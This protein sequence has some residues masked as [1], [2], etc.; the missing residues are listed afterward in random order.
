MTDIAKWGQVHV[1]IVSRNKVRRIK[2]EAKEFELKSRNLVQRKDWG[3]D[4]ATFLHIA[5]FKIFSGSICAQIQSRDRS[6]FYFQIM[7]NFLV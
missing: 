6:D 1:K 7:A 2:D 3:R 4:L 5:R